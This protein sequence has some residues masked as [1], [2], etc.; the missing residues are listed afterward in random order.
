VGDLT[1]DGIEDLA[2]GLA[3]PPSGTLGQVF[4]IAGQE[5]W[6]ETIDLHEESFATLLGRTG[7][8]ARE[9]TV[10]GDVDG[11]GLLD[12]LV[13]CEDWRE[14]DPV[15][16][17]LLPL[18][19]E[20]DGEL[21]VETFTVAQ[22][23]TVIERLEREW[24]FP[25]SVHAAAAGDVNDDDRPDLLFSDEGGAD[26]LRGISF[27]VP[28]RADLPRTI[29]LPTQP[30]EPW[31]GITRIFGSAQRVQ[32][33]RAFGQAGDWNGD[34]FEDVLIGEQNIE[35]FDPG[36]MFI[37]LGE[38]ELPAE[39]RLHRPGRRAV[40]LAG[41]Q[42]ITR[43]DNSTPRAADLNGDGRADFAFSE[44]SFGDLPAPDGTLSPG[45]VHVVYGI[46]SAVPFI[47][48]DANFDGRLNI[49]DPVY[50]LAFLFTG[51]ESPYCADAADADDSGGHNITDAIATLNHLFLGAEPLPAPY[52]REGEDP[53]ADGLGC[54]GY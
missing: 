8:F 40:R 15:Q 42:P 46:P 33:G 39:I 50:T 18:G 11:D 19:S 9:I 48:G 13:C 21:A 49:S 2:V 4:F 35:P 3:N 38:R 17:F 37:V 23:G 43:L 29:S 34:G 31:D 25:Y 10:P 16:A 52:P 41:T 24:V 54:L 20:L 36:N 53:T 1:G 27:L 32:S 51:G 26:S 44:T 12:L 30:P 14:P 45:A 7:S 6:P 47:R 28:G 5:T 22:G